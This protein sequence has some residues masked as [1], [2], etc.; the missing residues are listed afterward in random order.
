MIIDINNYLSWGE[1]RKQPHVANLPIKEQMQHYSL[2]SQQ[3]NM[4]RMQWLAENVRLMGSNTTTTSAAAA[5][6]GG[7][8]GTN[9]TPPP[10]PPTINSSFVAFGSY[11]NNTTP[12]GGYADRTS[13]GL[14][15][16]FT[17]S[18]L[19]TNPFNKDT[20]KFVTGSGVV[21]GYDT[22]VV[23]GTGFDAGLQGRSIFWSADGKDWNP[24][25]ASGISGSYYN[26][27]VAYGYSDN[28]L[29]DTSFVV[30]GSGSISTI[31]AVTVQ[32][33][34]WTYYTSTNYNGLRTVYNGK[35][36]GN[37]N[38]WLALGDTIGATQFGY[39]SSDTTNWT[40]ANS[41][42]ANTDVD[43][44]YSLAYAEDIGMWLA[45]VKPKGGTG[46]FIYTSTDGATW[47][48]G[49]NSTADIFTTACYAVAYIGNGTWLLGGDK[50]SGDGCIFTYDSQMN[51]AAPLNI[52]L[53][54]EC[55]SIAYDG[56]WAVAVGRVATPGS[57]TI[58]IYSG[59][60]TNGGSWVQS[61]TTASMWADGYAV[62][63]QNRQYMYP[64]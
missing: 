52:G 20:A 59:N 26:R 24:V 11:V 2:Y 47:T 7:G 48:A 18:Y 15:T 21:S 14:N 27:S 30:A 55:Y 5:A 29:A 35:D 1:F 23:V 25:D 17:A 41:N 61:T 49:D 33:G 12:V 32:G 42:I 13:P 46:R 63:S 60:P 37:N 22:F 28:T 10:P 44:I 36:G 6:G 57:N 54:D 64:Q 9:P 53:L 56:S 16:W 3:Y 43:S 50:R 8:H 40:V 4:M 62:A 51:A 34:I 31:P 19:V 45:G 58:I 39:Q 38:L